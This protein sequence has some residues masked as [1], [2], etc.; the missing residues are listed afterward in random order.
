MAKERTNADEILELADALHDLAK[1]YRKLSGVGTQESF[2]FNG[3]LADASRDTRQGLHSGAR[4]LQSLLDREED[5]IR[6]RGRQ[7][8][9]EADFGS[10]DRASVSLARHTGGNELYALWHIP[11]AGGGARRIVAYYGPL[12]EDELDTEALTY[13][14]EPLGELEHSSDPEQLGWLMSEQDDGGVEWLD[15]HLEPEDED[16]EAATAEEEA[17][18]DVA[19]AEEDAEAEAELATAEA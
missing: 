2:D 13:K 11:G 17:E 18:S 9:L 6:E 7:V 16:R 19:G 10:V 14:G 15:G 3:R 5:L 12:D 1:G 8:T 4:A